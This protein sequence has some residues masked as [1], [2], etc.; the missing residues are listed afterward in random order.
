MPA[1]TRPALH[2]LGQAEIG[3]E[4]AHCLVADTVLEASTSASGGGVSTSAVA[5]GRSGST[6]GGAAPMQQ[7]A[8]FIVGWLVAGE[9]QVLE[10]AVHPSARRRGLGAALLEGLL[11][12]CG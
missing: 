2:L 4:I 1:H 10:M 5:G 3:R 8:G 7:A 11:R 12:D 6:L 9:L